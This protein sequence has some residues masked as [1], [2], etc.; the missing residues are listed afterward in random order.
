MLII[1][2]FLPHAKL[3]TN[4]TLPVD[5]FKDATYKGR[6]IPKEKIAPSDNDDPINP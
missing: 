3:P 4:A 6:N 5:T 2:N 1:L